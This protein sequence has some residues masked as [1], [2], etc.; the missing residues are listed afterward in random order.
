MFV[1]ESF[2]SEYI[3]LALEIS[4]DSN[5]DDFV[6]L[7]LKTSYPLWSNDAKAKSCKRD[8]CAEYRRGNQDSSDEKLV[9]NKLEE[10]SRVT[11]RDKKWKLIV[12]PDRENEFYDIKR[13][14]LEQENLIGQGYNV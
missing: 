11:V 4:P 3:P 7:S 1:E 6:A 10:W 5:D 2:Y 14:P 9:E 13:D 8:N 12:N